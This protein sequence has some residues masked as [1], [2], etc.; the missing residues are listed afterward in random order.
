[1]QSRQA[2]QIV[3]DALREARVDERRAINNRAIVA[4][5]AAWGR[6][7]VDRAGVVSMCRKVLILNPKL[8]RATGG[9]K[10]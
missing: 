9:P 10:L 2:G 8:G 3:I 4:I 1:M 6:G 7:E 5:V